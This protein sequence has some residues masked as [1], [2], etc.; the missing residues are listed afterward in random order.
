MNPINTLPD[1]VP[2]FDGVTIGG[3]IYIKWKHQRDRT[4]YHHEMAHVLQQREYGWLFYPA[5]IWAWIMAGF[6]YYGN[7]FEI[8]AREYAAH[9]VMMERLKAG[10]KLP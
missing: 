3:H 10:S 6:S 8:D 9:T 2:Y 4:L 7:R 5:Y 1:W